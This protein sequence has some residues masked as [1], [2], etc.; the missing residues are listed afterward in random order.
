MNEE[1]V[2][3]T[4]A[5]ALEKARQEGQPIE[6]LLTAVQNGAELDAWFEPKEN[7]GCEL[8]IAVRDE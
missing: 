6:E 4:I 1:Q 2:E 5:S 8:I 7:G 3:K